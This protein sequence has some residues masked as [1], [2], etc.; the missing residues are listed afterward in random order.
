M[1]LTH[2]QICRV[3]SSVRKSGLAIPALG[4]MYFRSHVAETKMD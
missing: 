1:Y 2:L 4:S 3:A